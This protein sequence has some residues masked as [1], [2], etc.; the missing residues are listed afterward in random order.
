MGFFVEK[1]FYLVDRDIYLNGKLI[2]LARLISVF[3]P[4]EVPNKNTGF[5]SHLMPPEQWTQQTQ[6][7]PEG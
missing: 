3:S 1:V 6:V 5:E 7:P 2:K 4:K